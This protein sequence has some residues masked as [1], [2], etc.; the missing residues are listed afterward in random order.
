MDISL[1][2][3]LVLLSIY[4]FAGLFFLYSGRIATTNIERF[5]SGLVLIVH[6]A[7]LLTI[8][9]HI[10]TSLAALAQGQESTVY[11]RDQVK[12]FIPIIACLGGIFTFLFGGVGTNL[13]SASLIAKDNTEILSYLEKLDARVETI[14]NYMGQKQ[15]SNYSRIL[16]NVVFLV[17]VLLGIYSQL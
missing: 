8:V 17:F 10:S 16:F 9:G 4:G 11:I 2:K 7:F 12:E 14:E 5:F 15:Q 1:Q 6:T 13:V 3:V